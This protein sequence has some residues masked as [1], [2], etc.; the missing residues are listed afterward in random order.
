M[1]PKWQEVSSSNIA[2]IAY[3]AGDPAETDLG[4]LYVR[5]SSGAEYAYADVPAQ[6]AEDLFTAESVGRVFY[7][8]VRD[9]FKA[10]KIEPDDI[11]AEEEAEGEAF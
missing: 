8:K 11:D 4:E 2:A 1:E 5:F 3:V 7:A 6:V 10:A 9:Q